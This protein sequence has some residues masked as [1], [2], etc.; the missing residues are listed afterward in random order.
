MEDEAEGAQGR[1]SDE[2][3]E[4]DR[5]RGREIVAVRLDRS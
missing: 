5:E 1:E 2:G 3:Q 4:G